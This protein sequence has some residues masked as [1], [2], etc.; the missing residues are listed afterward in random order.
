M[1]P[2]GVPGKM[3]FFVLGVDTYECDG[4]GGMQN[5][6]EAGRD[7]TEGTSGSTEGGKAGCF[8]QN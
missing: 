7:V 2:L 8:S 4:F 3:C 6:Q 1:F 5:A